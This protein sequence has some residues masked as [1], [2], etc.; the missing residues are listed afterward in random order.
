[1]IAGLKKVSGAACVFLL[2]IAWFTIHWLAF[3]PGFLYFD[4]F[5]L[6]EKMLV[7]NQPFYYIGWESL[8]YSLLVHTAARVRPDLAVMTFAQIVFAGAMIAYGFFLL[9][10]KMNQ[11][12]LA[13]LFSILVIFLPA[14]A[15]MVILAERDVIFG[16]LGLFILFRLM[17]LWIQP[18]EIR[19]RQ[20]FL[21][22]LL[23]LAFAG[24]R[25]EALV[26][27]LILPFQLRLIGLPLR[28][29]RLFA[30]Y[31]WGAGTA[32]YVLAPAALGLGS[33]YGNPRD[34]YDL[35]AVLKPAFYILTHRGQALTGE[36][37]AVLSRLM[38]P[39][40]I[41]EFN[42]KS[43]LDLGWF[44]PEKTVQ[45]CERV[46]ALALGLIWQ[47]PG[48]F[49][50][51]R[52]AAMRPLAE[53]PFLDWRHEFYREGSNP[54]FY[55][56]RDKLSLWPQSK[57]E[58]FRRWS[59]WSWDLWQES[60]WGLMFFMTPFV[61]ILFGVLFFPL[62]WRFPGAAV[63]FAAPGLHVMIVLALA[64]APN[65]KYFYFSYLSSCYFIPAL[66]FEYT[67]AH[68]A[69]KAAK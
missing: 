67:R 31:L 36:E 48:L 62:A 64:A 45:D 60:E 55:A 63:T 51:S 6:L 29:A 28:M 25:K 2:A 16:W 52:L 20:I 38:D 68:R 33:M 30:L 18:E 65:G 13:W 17:H 41:P 58:G 9:R 15:Y 4:I 10:Y 37:A 5:F 11:P 35:N 8:L 7:E 50:R 61:A 24:L 39:K 23:A 40:M 1:M 22:G 44:N 49:F 53:N 56:L 59:E 14:Q 3:W 47:N 43:Y 57:W 46:E 26:F 69:G 42:Q 32:I 27:L 12:R 21:L 66:W 54:R 34:C 19:G